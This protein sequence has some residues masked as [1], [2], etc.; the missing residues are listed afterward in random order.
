[1]GRLRN[2]GPVIT[3]LLLFNTMALAELP[4]APQSENTSGAQ[5]NEV[6]VTATRYEEPVGTVP[7]HVTVITEEEIANST[8]KDIPSLLGKEAGL[9]AYD[10]TGNRRS[11]RIDRSGFGETAVLN[12]LVL[13]D[14]RRVNNP[15]LSGTDWLLIPLDRVKRIEI[16]R[17]SSGSIIYG[18]NATDSVINI[19]TKEGGG[20]LKAGVSGG[21]GSYDTYRGSANIDGSYHDLSFAVSGFLHRSDGFR[22]NSDTDQ[23]NVGMNF[24]YFLGEQAVIGFS[25]AYHED[26]TSLPGA[27][28]QSELEAGFSREDTSSPSDFSDTEDGYILFKPEIFFL[29]DSQ[30]VMS[31][32]YRK[33]EQ[34]F[35]STFLGGEFQGNTD[36]E[37]IIS[38]PQVVLNTPIAG[39]TNS[40]TIGLDYIDAEEDIRNRTLFFDTIDIGTFEIQK[41][42][43]A[44][45][46]HNEFHP[47]KKIVLSAGYRYDTVEYQ[48][49]PTMPGTP[50]ETDFDVN[51]FTA[52]MNYR[53]SNNSYF[54]VNYSE[55]FRYPVMDELF[56][57]FTNTIIT[58]LKPQQSDNIELGFRHYLTDWLYTTINFFRLD[59]EDEIF[60]NPSTFSNANLDGETRREGIEMVLGFDLANIDLT[61]TY[62]YRKS[63]IRGGVFEGKEVPNVPNHQ[64][65]IDAAWYL[66]D[67]W[68]VVVSGVYAGERYLESDYANFFPKQDD[69]V[70][71]GSKLKYQWRNWMFFLDANNLLDEKYSGY[72]V[73]SVPPVEPAF[74]PSPDRNF[75]IGARFDY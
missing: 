52:G 18:D 62:T 6:I 9:H 23:K 71:F 5:M 38:S 2:V 8:A 17:G 51:L 11:Y 12:T 36:I 65:S 54:Y 75:L 41:N 68:T 39:F 70:V 46:L 19:I 10:I 28:R 73:L 67:N 50:D 47:S 29:E 20:D 60:F 1:M 59:T 34:T 24:D 21:A 26:N 35:F 55:G 64:A 13:T 15:D 42:N 48:F 43:K 63:E 7:A 4:P 22:D 58:D 37:T 31:F 27:L 44:F 72:G 25:G 53:Y 74:Y 14:G 32:S 40:L 57:F 16:I 69:Y 56:S 3:A 66:M 45:Y 33:R 49:S 61:G 30:F